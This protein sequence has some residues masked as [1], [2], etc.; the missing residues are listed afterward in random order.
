M[1]KVLWTDCSQLGD[2]YLRAVM[3]LRSD[4]GKSDGYLKDRL[5]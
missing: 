1:F 3:C 4:I 2:P 5:G